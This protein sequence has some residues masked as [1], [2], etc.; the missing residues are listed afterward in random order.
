M[1]QCL[2]ASSLAMWVGFTLQ[3]VVRVR[4]VLPHEQVDDVSVTCAP[5]ASKVQVGQEMIPP[6]RHRRGFAC[7]AFQLCA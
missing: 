1:Q 6:T 2:W 4:P 5:D 3:V 7:S